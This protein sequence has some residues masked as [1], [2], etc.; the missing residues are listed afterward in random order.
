MHNV[1]FTLDGQTKPHIMDVNAKIFET[2]TNLG[3]FYWSI[4]REGQLTSLPIK[5]RNERNIFRQKQY[6]TKEAKRGMCR[7]RGS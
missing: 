5:S 7:V 4:H 3:R 1:N 6:T 2:Q